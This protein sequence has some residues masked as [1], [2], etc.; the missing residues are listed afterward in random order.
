MKPSRLAAIA[1][2]GWLLIWMGIAYLATEIQYTDWPQPR[3][4]KVHELCGQAA[5]AGM[6]GFVVWAVYLGRRRQ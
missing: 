1:A 6:V 5:G 2:V 4:D 3:K